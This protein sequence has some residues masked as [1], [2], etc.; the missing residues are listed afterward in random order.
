MVED[1][2]PVVGKKWENGGMVF[3]GLKVRF[4]SIWVE[5]GWV[6][7]IGVSGLVERLGNVVLGEM[8]EEVGMND[9]VVWP[10]VGMWESCIM[11]LGVNGEVGE[12]MTLFHLI[13]TR[14]FLNVLSISGSNK[15]G[16]DSW[17]PLVC[18]HLKY[19]HTKHNQCKPENNKQNY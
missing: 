9:E 7:W 10:V 8:C 12:S 17:E 4:G 13:K 1:D 11:F 14:F 18:I 19:L 2:W 15:S 5:L 3:D 6:V 16:D